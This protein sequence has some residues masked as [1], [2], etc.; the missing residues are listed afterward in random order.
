MRIC[1]D[2]AS[3]QAGNIR[4]YVITTQKNQCHKILSQKSQ[5]VYAFLLENS[6]GGLGSRRERFS[7]NVSL[8]DYIP[9]QL[10]LKSILPLKVAATLRGSRNSAVGAQLSH[11]Y[12]WCQ[13]YKL[14]LQALTYV[15]RNQLRGSADP[16]KF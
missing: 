6:P 8:F 5:K 14:T 12:S 11:T 2:K 4:V 16:C 13:S 1:I 3:S 7:G 15:G 10:I 9:K